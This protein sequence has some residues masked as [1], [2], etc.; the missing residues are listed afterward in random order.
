MALPRGE[1]RY[2]KDLSVFSITSVFSVRAHG[3]VGARRALPLS[4]RQTAKT[5]PQRTYAHIR[6]HARTRIQPLSLPISARSPPSP[7][8]LSSFR[9]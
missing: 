8:P 1:T 3:R 2:I 5:P 4:G 9:C 6:T 7:L